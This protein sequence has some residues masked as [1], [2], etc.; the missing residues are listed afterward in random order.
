MKPSKRIVLVVAA[1]LLAL[2]GIAVARV[3]AERV[4]SAPG[5]HAAV[6]RVKVR[7]GESLRSVLGS[8]ATSGA[9]EQPRMVE[10]ALRLAGREARV[11][12][13]TYDLPARASPG[14]V[15]HGRRGLAVPRPAAGAGGAP[16]GPR[17]PARAQR[18]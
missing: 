5:P 11:R 6:V 2:A 16:R 14:E 17:D 15:P 10:A 4:L 1:A 3:V 8:L 13:G 9:L 7:T 18:R 12:A